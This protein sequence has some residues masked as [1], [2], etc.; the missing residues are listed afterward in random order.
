[1]IV[2]NVYFEEKIRQCNDFETAFAVLSSFMY[3]NQSKFMAYQLE[4]EQ[5]NVVNL[6][7]GFTVGQI[8]KINLKE[9]N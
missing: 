2:Y 3:I 9:K 7:Y 4:C 6:V 1:M 5:H 8:V